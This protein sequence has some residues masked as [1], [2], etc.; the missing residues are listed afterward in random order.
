[1][2][3]QRFARLLALGFTLATAVAL[4]VSADS[5]GF[6]PTEY[7]LVSIGNAHVDVAQIE[8]AARA[9]GMPV[10][11]VDGNNITT[12]GQ[13]ATIPELLNGDQL[14]VLDGDRVLLRATESGFAYTLRPAAGGYEL[15][16]EPTEQIDRMNTLVSVL[17]NLQASGVTGIDLSVDLSSIPSYNVSAVKGPAAPAGVSIDSDLYGLLVSSNWFAYAGSHQLTLVGLRVEVVAEK[18]PDGTVSEAFQP[19]ITS[20]TDGL[21]KLLL[22]IEQLTALAQ[23]EG[24]GYV[25]P[26]YPAIAP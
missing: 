20:D 17:T 24:V 22:P 6:A 16:I 12:D 1:M 21:S 15:V 10:V 7:Y 5:E 26:A 18:L 3:I 19:Y 14:L 2:M 25:R 11:L 9:D 4:I 8:S 13:D 23:G